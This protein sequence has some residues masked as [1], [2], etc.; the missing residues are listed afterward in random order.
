MTKRN[1]KRI[2]PKTFVSASSAGSLLQRGLFQALLRVDKSGGR[3][4]ACDHARKPSSRLSNFIVLQPD[5]PP[6]KSTEEMA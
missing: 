5:A 2:S 6:K 4:R 3:S 1:T